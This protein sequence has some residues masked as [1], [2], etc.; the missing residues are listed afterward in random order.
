MRHA[1]EHGKQVFV[2]YIYQLNPQ[3]RKKPVSVMDLVS[4]RSWGEFESLERDAWG[5]PTV[6]ETSIKERQQILKCADTQHHSCARR[7]Q[8]E[9]SL[10][11]ESPEG[12]LDI[13]VMP[14]VAF[15]RGLGRLGH[16]KG[17]YDYFLQRY[18]S[19]TM[20]PMPFLGMFLRFSDVSMHRFPNI[21]PVGL[22]LDVQLL[23]EPEV[24]PVGATDWRLKALVVGDGTVIRE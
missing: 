18:H 16:G 22:A 10:A 4:L 3:D 13:I 21:A 1:F 23:S 7:A 14:G 15:D 5:I 9:D 11:K 24:V 6:A 12:R 8:T 17:F 2:P 20:A 19:A